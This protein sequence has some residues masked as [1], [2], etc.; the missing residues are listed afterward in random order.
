MHPVS[1][2]DRIS[3]P[4][5]SGSRDLKRYDSSCTVHPVDLV[6]LDQEA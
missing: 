5:S 6:E 3:C 4:G 1:D 2:L